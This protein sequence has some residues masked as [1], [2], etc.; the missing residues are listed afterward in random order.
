MNEAD[1]PHHS[2][3]SWWSDRHIWRRDIDKVLCLT[4]LCAGSYA[5]M[6]MEHGNYRRS[7]DGVDL[8]V[9]VEISQSSTVH[10]SHSIEFQDVPDFFEFSQFTGTRGHAYKPYKP[11]SDCTVRMNFFANRVINAWSNLPTSVSFVSLPAFS[12]SIRSVDFRNFL[13]CNSC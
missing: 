10:D 13:K 4:I 11:R 9:G 12:R 8:P 7:P 6:C 1:V 3:S 2:P 5:K